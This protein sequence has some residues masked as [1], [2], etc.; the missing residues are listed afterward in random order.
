MMDECYECGG[1]GKVCNLCGEEPSACECD[2]FDIE[3]AFEANE[4]QHYG[5][6]EV[7]GEDGT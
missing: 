7:C 2:E 6:C 4:L 3:E 5:P 1:T